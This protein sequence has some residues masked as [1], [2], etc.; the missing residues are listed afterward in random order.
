MGDLERE[1][2]KRTLS[3]ALALT[4]AA[5]SPMI[6]THGVPNLA[7]VDDNVWRSGQITT[8]E[9]WDTIAA[10]AAGRA[11]HVLKLN[12]DAEGSDA[13]AVARGFD[14]HL[15]AIDPQGDQDV[16]DDLAAA[17]RQPSPARLAE[18]EALLA[19][20]HAHVATDIYLVHCTHGQDRTGLVIGEHR[21]LHDGWAPQRAYDEMRAHHF[22]SALHGVHETW[23]RFARAS[24]TV[25]GS[26]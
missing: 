9:G 15:L 3:L 16:W 19:D 10:L 5:C 25:K 6:Y 8:A 14:V 7:R 12:F 17:F 23:E 2:M 20:A 21:V 11:I 18:I 13:L 1:A 4:L 26:P 22:H 24:A